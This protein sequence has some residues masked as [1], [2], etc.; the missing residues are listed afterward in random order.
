MS[1]TASSS[2]IGRVCNLS[3][4]ICKCATDSHVTDYKGSVYYPP[5]NVNVDNSSVQF[6][7]ARPTEPDD[8]ERFP[9]IGVMGFWFTLST[10][11]T[12]LRADYCTRLQGAVEFHPSQLLSRVLRY[13]PSN[14]DTLPFCSVGSRAVCFV[15]FRVAGI[16]H[17]SD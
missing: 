15:A 16:T 17:I 6:R 1:H 14:S 2:V 3:F 13:A 11:G 12:M 9:V 10:V 5:V 8:N 7:M 4:V